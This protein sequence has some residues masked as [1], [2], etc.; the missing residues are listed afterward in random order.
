MGAY[1]SV[2]T[3]YDPGYLLRESSKG[4]EGYY[5]S[6]VEEIGEPPGVW[7][8]RAC[9][10]LGLEH[11]AEVEPAV[12]EAIY[13]RLLDPRDPG[14]L[15]PEVPDKDKDHLGA[16]PRRYKSTAGRLAELLAR[17]PD[18]TPERRE[19]LEIQAR[20]DQRQ[21]VLFF[22][23]TFS[24]D[25]STSVLHASLQAAM[26][27][28]ERAGDADAAAGYARQ[29]RAVE[30]AIM[31]GSAA[32]IEY[33]QD[34]AG[35]SR[36]GYHGAIPRDEQGRPLARH[37]TGRYVDAHQWTV[38]SFFQHTSRDG[39]PQL[40]VHNA[41]LNRAEC[42]DDGV[43]RTLDSRALH[44]ARAAASAIGGRVLDERIARELAAAY[45]QRPD[46]HGRELTGVPQQVKDR[47]SSR[48]AVVT[49]GVAELAA[50]YEA[51]H[52][53]PPNARALFSMA[54]YVTLNSR[55]AK[56]KRRHA[57]TRAELLDGWAAQ[58]T[59]A[60]LGALADIPARVLGSLD[61]AGP[62][63]AA[64][65]DEEIGR[66]LAVA[67]AEVQAA[68]AVWGRGQLLAAID[69]QL[70]GWLGGLDA[71]AVRAL[72]EDLT[73]QA[74]TGYGV[75]NLEAPD[76]V[77]M[78]AALRRKDGRSIYTPHDR[79]LYTTQPQLDAEEQLLTAAGQPGGPAA[80]AT[81]AAA[82]AALGAAPADLEALP[83]RVPPAAATAVPADVDE[84]HD[85]RRYT[86]GLRPDQAAAVYGILTSGRPVDVLIGPAGTGKSRT[87]GTLA[88]L[89][90]KLTGGQVVGVALAENAAQVLAAEGLPDAHNIARF[91][92]MAGRGQAALAAGDL[93]IVDEAGMVPTAEVTALH[94][95]A[96]AAGA[97]LLLTG[98][99]AQLP[100]V[101]AGGALGMLAREHGYYQLT[102]VQR[103]AEQWEREASLLLREGDAGA[104]ADYDR[105]GRLSE[106]TAEDM[107]TAAYRNWLADQLS[108]LDS[109]L[110]ARSNDQAAE[111][112]ARARADLASLGLVD[113]HAPITLA[114]GNHAGTGDLVQARHNDHAIEDHDGRWA[115][116]RDIW[117]IEGYVRKPRTRD[118]AKVIVRHDLGRD[119]DTGERQWSAPFQVPEEYLAA[120]AVLAY[121][122][123]VHAAQGRTVDTCHAL[124]D[125]AT[126]RALLYVMLTRGR[127]ANYAYS[128][129]EAP[130]G[131]RPEHA[132]EAGPGGQRTST[133]LRAGTRPAPALGEHQ[134]QDDAAV[135]DPDAPWAPEADRLSV[136]I[137]ALDR[138]E[139]DVPALDVLRDELARAVHLAHVG[140]IWAD[141][142]AEESGR[143]YDAIL[144]RLLTPEQ[145]GRYQAEDARNT[146]Y[147]QVRTA[148]L[149]G[150]DPARLLAAAVA[151]R[152]L[153][154]DPHRGPADD[155]SRVLHYRIREEIAGDPV[156][157]PASYTDRTPP[158]ADPEIAAVMI[159]L[160]RHMDQRTAELGERAA[161]DPP[162]WA[163]A[164]LG[165][166]PAE[167]QARAQW[168]RRAGPAAAYREQYGWTHPGQ[169]IGREPRAPEARAAWHAAAEALGRD[170]GTGA[171]LTAASDGDLH[172]AR[173][174]Y[175][176]ELEWAPPHVGEQ[177]R[178]TA[179]A[180]REQHTEAVLTRAR[181]RAAAGPGRS[182]LTARAEG[183]EQL[184]AALTT[185]EQE[186]A[187]ADEQRAAWHQAT[188][189]AREEAAAAT[190]ELR[191]R[192]PDAGRL[193]FRDPRHHDDPG[194]G[195]EHQ[196]H[197]PGPLAGTAEREA[198]EAELRHGA[199]AASRARRHLDRDATE[200]EA[201]DADRDQRDRE[202]PDRTR[203]PHKNPY[204]SAEPREPTAAEI[205]ARNFPRNPRPSP[206]RPPDPDPYERTRRPHEPPHRDGPSP[207]R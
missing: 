53:H 60:E 45:A 111:L 185:R 85:G 165:P 20:K 144:Q 74:L 79:A 52:G 120:H 175:E 100:S 198:A 176:R 196:D 76:L 180:R 18:A 199:D 28:A 150:H 3:G 49:A 141:L 61:P 110:I 108:G 4:A 113:G 134:D 14:M 39:D 35:Y 194:T 107:G 160:A 94:H 33:L 157:R 162:P 142:A 70:P 97:K 151:L 31:A 184:L 172:A 168:A 23:F 99:P 59:A 177:L 136:L 206:P 90:P 200:R 159:A 181:A 77:Q 5:L 153:D 89:W 22:D 104:L 166:V 36:A 170:A 139:Q 133:D 171:D 87:M 204:R 122:G 63:I 143:R 8:G 62:G 135:I 43:W 147:R 93:L 195:R 155:I 197:D 65:A 69:A 173:A 55:R 82:A 114:D 78:P 109:L 86:G 50:A 48:R 193:P 34:E 102:T 186:L 129:T 132:A 154:D 13:G 56:P 192:W 130:T 96:Q 191:R 128:I 125:Q 152:T 179:R 75:V 131:R 32:A 95:I 145:Y 190:A 105:H 25:K 188:E 24:V 51:H 203:W 178:A 116:N 205:A 30:D 84:H 202:E 101:G 183:H 112:A 2:S 64:L 72:L 66:V 167:P 115:A 46:G 17:E 37:A 119:P 124:V 80:T 29:A 38:A 98:D 40:H 73:S 67:V 1:G 103:M 156:P 106:G 164:G 58:M 140:A 146:L 57:P 121:A 92:A 83:G 189:T 201:A 149:A 42:D 137:A 6:A 91:L 54:Q 12:M 127:L 19:Q 118:P 44:R 7:T 88:D 11:G 68:H 158:A 169:P 123:T 174:R 27:R 71:A 15:D 182:P 21:A 16:A 148:E 161:Q 41:I 26:A 9:P 10:A 126:T 117:R 187:A 47:F 81:A 138:D 163:L 207:S